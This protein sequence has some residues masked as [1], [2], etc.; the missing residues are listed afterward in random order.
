MTHK[1][2]RFAVAVALLA[3]NAV[4]VQARDL[5]PPFTPGEVDARV[6]ADTTHG[7]IV[8]TG[9]LTERGRSVGGHVAVV[10][11]PNEDFNR[12]LK[13]GSTV[14]T[15]TLGW[16][17]VAPNGTFS[18]RIAPERLRPE[19]VNADGAVNL[20]AI[21]WTAT[22]SGRWGFPAKVERGDQFRVIS[23][24]ESLEISASSAIEA[25]SISTIGAADAVTPAAA[26]CWWSLKSSYDAQSVIGEGWPYG[27]HKSWM[28]SASSQSMTV[29]AAS[30]SS[31]ASG[32]WSVSGTTS[33]S[34]GVTF[35]WDESIV[36]RDYRVV[37]HYSK[38]QYV[39]NG[40]PFNQWWAHVDYPTGGYV[41]TGLSGY[42]SWSN[43]QPASAGVWARDQSTGNAYEV[44]AGVKL[45]GFLGINLSLKSN[46]STGHTLYYR[47]TAAGHV[48]GNDAAP[49]LASKVE[50]AS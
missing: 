7:P 42:P 40:A 5:P 44:S 3:F 6:F 36:Y 28:K 31:G 19:Y 46:Y 14:R 1:F 37:L 48:C 25:G 49:S 29:G 17:R 24:P 47:L 41:D 18:V 39:C 30:S 16:A 22:A 38:Y 32:S 4:A 50:T 23:D 21:G 2:A 35:T 45:L 11:W 26:S 8:A 34:S 10:A 13:P 12:T 27:T 33:T 43:C 9:H 15:L 20:M